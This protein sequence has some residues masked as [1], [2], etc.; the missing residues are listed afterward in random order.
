MADLDQVLTEQVKRVNSFYTYL[1]RIYMLEGNDDDYDI[2]ESYFAEIKRVDVRKRLGKVDRSLSEDQL[3]IKI[4]KAILQMIQQR[5]R[6]DPAHNQM[7]IDDIDWPP[8]AKLLAIVR[9]K[10]LS[11][12]KIVKK[13][14]RG[15]GLR[16]DI[17]GLSATYYGK[18][19]LKQ[20]DF[21]RRRVVDTAELEVLRKACRKI[22][23]ELPEVVEPTTTE[24]YFQSV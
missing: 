20:I 23:M 2:C 15:T 21:G 6:K 12:V 10:E 19:I 16:Y 18:K 5:L 8:L 22:K 4:E 14:G 9:L 7:F 17:T 3:R 24:R 11:E 1:H 13:G